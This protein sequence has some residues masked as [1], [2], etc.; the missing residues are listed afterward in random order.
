MGVALKTT[1]TVLVSQSMYKKHYTIHLKFTSIVHKIFQE[2][3]S[4]AEM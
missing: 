2:N 1:K 3:L 4:Y